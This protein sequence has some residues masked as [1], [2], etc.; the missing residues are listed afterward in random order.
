MHIIIKRKPTSMDEVVPW[1]RYSTYDS[2][3]YC[4]WITIYYTYYYI[5]FYHKI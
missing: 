3:K 4:N 5:P 2:N 1:A